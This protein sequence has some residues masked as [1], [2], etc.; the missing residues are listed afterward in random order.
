MH[1][2]AF[3]ATIPTY[4]YLS[5]EGPP[6]KAEL[7]SASGK[8]EPSTGAGGFIHTACTV[9]L[10]GMTASE[11]LVWVVVRDAEINYLHYTHF[12][13]FPYFDSCGVEVKNCCKMMKKY[14]KSLF[15]WVDHG[16]EKSE[17]FFQNSTLFNFDCRST[18]NPFCWLL[19]FEYWKRLNGRQ[20][21]YFRYCMFWMHVWQST[22]NITVYRAVFSSLVAFDTENIVNIKQM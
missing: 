9:G 10:G 21:R 11:T 12:G 4:F 5:K 2:L 8:T 7:A 6:A 15:S 3:F 14:E 18:A 19:S 17:Y 22:A 1:H 20:C 16:P 13:I